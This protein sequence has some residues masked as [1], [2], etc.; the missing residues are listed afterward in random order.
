[1][2]FPPAVFILQISGKTKIYI[3][4]IA[5]LQYNLL[6]IFILQTQMKGL[7]L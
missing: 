5:D 3:E 1:M 4:K 7:N 6:C 2:D